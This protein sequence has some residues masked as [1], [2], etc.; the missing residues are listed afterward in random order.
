MR[1]WTRS[2]TS[3]GLAPDAR[4]RAA[5]PRPDL[6]ARLCQVRSV[7]A[8]A[9][10]RSV[11]SDAHRRRRAAG[12]SGRCATSAAAAGSGKATIRPASKAARGSMRNEL[13]CMGFATRRRA[14]R[15]RYCATVARRSCQTRS[16]SFTF[17]PPERGMTDTLLFRAD[18]L[19]RR[20]HRH[21]PRRRLVRARGRAGR[22]QPGRGQPARPRLARRRHDAAL[23]RR[24]CSKA[25]LARRR[26]TS[27]IAPT[28][29]RCCTLD[30]CQ[31]YGQVI[32]AEAM[33]LGIE[34]AQAARR[35]R[36]RPG[37][38]APPRPHRPLGRAV[39]SARAWSSIHFVNVLSRPIVAPFGGRDARIGTNPFCVGIPRAGQGADRPRLRHQQDRPGQ[40]PRRLQQ[41][42]SSSSPARSST[43]TASRRPTRAS[44]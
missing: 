39:Q 19:G 38:F 33:A 13:G 11:R 44:P 22:R 10:G 20:R 17:A 29:A 2:L 37:A 28:A 43:T 15:R 26:S 1:R 18:A 40:D 23:H 5:A 24:A 21:R 42:R 3:V 12:R 41:G 7:T 35:L 36:R 34:R 4:W 16:L 9:E 8:V 27:E 32:G 25:A 31:G 14:L 30:G 6:R